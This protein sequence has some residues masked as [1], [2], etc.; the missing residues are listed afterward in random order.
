MTN[1]PGPNSPLAPRPDGTTIVEPSWSARPPTLRL[2][3]ADDG[4]GYTLVVVGEID[5]TT[6]NVLEDAVRRAAEAPSA[7]VVIDLREVDF[8]DLAGVRAIADAHARLDGR[9]RLLRAPAPVQSVFRLVSV[10]ATLPF[11]S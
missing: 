11:E 3:V 9:L 8:I 2:E 10:E 6:V 7:T 1:H 5:L 4:R